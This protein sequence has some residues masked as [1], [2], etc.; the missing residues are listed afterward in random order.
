ME[1][2]ISTIVGQ[3][4]TTFGTRTR[5]VVF[6]VNLFVLNDNPLY[7]PRFISM[8]LLIAQHKMASGKRYTRHYMHHISI[9]HI[10]FGS[11]E[12]PYSFLHIIYLYL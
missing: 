6:W 12:W 1:F 8:R 10:G 2:V 9:R 5:L 11:T 4:T 7:S 3:N